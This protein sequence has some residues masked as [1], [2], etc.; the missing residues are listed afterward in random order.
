MDEGSPYFVFPFGNKRQLADFV[1][2]KVGWR[3]H[4]RHPRLYT[5]LL[6]RCI[7]VTYFRV[8]SMLLIVKLGG[9]E[10]PIYLEC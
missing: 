1:L 8:S 6:I 4:L 5:G 10:A 9:W 7:C 3:S 2:L